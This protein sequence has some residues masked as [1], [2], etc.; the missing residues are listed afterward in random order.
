MGISV[1]EVQRI[2]DLAKLD[3]EESELLRY[4]E[5]LND[6]LAFVETLERPL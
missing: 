2:A 6:I 3:F 5:Q 1:D 4:A